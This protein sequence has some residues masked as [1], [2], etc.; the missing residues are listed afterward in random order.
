MIPRHLELRVFSYVTQVHNILLVGNSRSGKSTL[1]RRC[2]KDVDKSHMRIWSP[3]RGSVVV[4]FPLYITCNFIR[5]NELGGLG[6]Y[7]PQP[8]ADLRES[9]HI[10]IVVKNGAYVVNL[11]EDVVWFMKRYKSLNKPFTII[12]NMRTLDDTITDTDSWVLS[13]FETSGVRHVVIPSLDSLARP[14]DIRR[15]LRVSS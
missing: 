5:M 10:F 2:W 1:I 15:L 12:V 7:R 9:T 11:L 4:S 13:A 14:A 3:R 6:K 8:F